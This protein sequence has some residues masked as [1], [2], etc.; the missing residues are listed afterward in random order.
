M[1]TGQDRQLTRLT[2]QPQG[3]TWSP[4]GTRIAFFD[5]DGMWRR[6]PV[7][8]VDVATGAVTRIHES[9]FAPGN[10]TWSPDGT[11][12]AVAHGGVRT[13]RASARAPTRC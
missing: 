3:A 4:D 9:L 8:V 13:R 5:V 1:A 6:A 2:T 11:R 7:S 10:P 12:V